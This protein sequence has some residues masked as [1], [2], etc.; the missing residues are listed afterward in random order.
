MMKEN[1]KK[2]KLRNEDWKLKK[3]M[4]Y[5]KGEALYWKKKAEGGEKQENIVNEAREDKRNILE[6]T[7]DNV[8][9]VGSK[10]KEIEITYEM[11]RDKHEVNPGE[12]MSAV[13]GYESSK[14]GPNDE[15]EVG[16]ATP[17]QA[18][19]KGEENPDTDRGQSSTIESNA[20]IISKYEAVRNRN[21]KELKAVLEASEVMGVKKVIENELNKKK[22][23]KLN[24]KREKQKIVMITSRRSERNSGRKRNY[25]EMVNMDEE[26]DQNDPYQPGEEEESCDPDNEGIA[27][28]PANKVS[29][30][31]QTSLSLNKKPFSCTVT[32][33]ATEVKESFKCSK[34]RCHKEFRTENGLNSHIEMKHPDIKSFKCDACNAAFATGKGLKIHKYRNNCYST[35]ERISLCEVCSNSFGSKIKLKN[36]MDAKH[37]DSY[38]CGV[39]GKV[40]SN[41][42]MWRLHNKSCSKKENKAKLSR[43]NSGV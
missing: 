10:D 21:M 1:L 2:I 18:V 39:C 6:V 36:H 12:G 33:P 40:L 17:D 9:D 26:D 25:G 35:Q 34:G 29:R 14:I 30:Q 41:Y 3:Y 8:M 20:I 24:K 19:D 7:E 5:W 43:A 28:E 27:T 38:T 42:N 4:H 13:E 32:L 31:D 22:E 11:D 37:K 15:A 16:E 23:N